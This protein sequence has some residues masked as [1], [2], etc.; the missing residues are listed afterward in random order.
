MFHSAVLIIPTKPC[1]IKG[2]TSSWLENHDNQLCLASTGGLLPWL[3]TIAEKA[4]DSCLFWT[5]EQYRLKF[6]KLAHCNVRSTGMEMGFQKHFGA[7]GRGGFEV[8]N[9]TL[10]YLD[11]NTW[12]RSALC[13]IIIYLLTSNTYAF[14]FDVQISLSGKRKRGTAIAKLVDQYFYKNLAMLWCPMQYTIYS[15]HILTRYIR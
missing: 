6:M 1:F 4:A 3:H 2:S 9:L 11:P 8:T 7:G 14:N 15:C 10:N 5:S 13:V 12:L